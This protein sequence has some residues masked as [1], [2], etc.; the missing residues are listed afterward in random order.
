MRNVSKLFGMIALL[1]ISA[2]SCQDT[3]AQTINENEG[4]E[5]STVYF[6]SEISPEAL[7]KIY[8]AVGKKA[9]GRV[10]V[11]IST[12]ESNNSNHLDPQLIKNLVQSV[13]G[14][15]VE[16]NT[17]YGGSRSTTA[18]HR[19]AIAQRG[20][21]DIAA[22]DIMDEEGSIDIPVSRYEALAV[23]PRGQSS[24]QL[25]LPDQPCAF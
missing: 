16:C 20:Y 17:A 5:R 10:A 25:R 22:V 8:E 19:R 6:T 3:G 12:G 4:G 15:L 14:T 13:N 21:D 18:N 1:A 9:E 23:R 11:K 24:G 7:V 2:M